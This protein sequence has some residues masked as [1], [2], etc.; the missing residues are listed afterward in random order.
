MRFCWTNLARGVAEAGCL[1]FRDSSVASGRVRGLS[2][3]LKICLAGY[4][5]VDV[6]QRKVPRVF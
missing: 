1:E 6:V 2:T 4:R 5:F 3:V